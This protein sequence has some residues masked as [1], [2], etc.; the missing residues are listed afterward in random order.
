MP[1]MISKS[2]IFN[3]TGSIEVTFR[4]TMT[5]KFMYTRLDINGSSTG[6]D[7]KKGSEGALD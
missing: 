5:E 4:E 3:S 1:R 6:V 2:I 7:T